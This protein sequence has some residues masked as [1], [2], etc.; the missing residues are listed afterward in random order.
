MNTRSSIL[1]RLTALR[2]SLPM[3]EPGARGLERVA[4]NP[5]CTRLRA[6]TIVGITPATAAT[7]VYGEPDREGISPFT[8]GLGIRF[9]RNLFEN[10]A[11]RLLQLYRDAGRL[12]TTECKVTI[13]PDL[14]P[15]LAT[16]NAAKLADTLARRQA[17]TDRLLRKK[18]AG[19]ADAPNIIIK[20]RMFVQ[21]LGIGHAVEPDALVA[22]DADRFYRPVEVKSY[23]DRDG[24]TEPSDIR[25][26]CRQAAVGIVALRSAASQFGLPISA[27]PAVGDLVLRVPG[28]MAAKLRPMT[29]SAEVASLDRAIGEAPRNLDELEAMLPQGG[30][31]DLPAILDQ[32]PTNYRTSCKE[33]CA[34]AGKCKQ[35]AVANGDPSLLGDA[36]RELL[37]AAGTLTRALDLMN[38]RGAPPRTAE[39]QVLAE[40][41]QEALA[42]YRRAI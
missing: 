40:Q 6:L 8:M 39:E 10:S 15:P 5:E 18:A 21:L 7:E 4:R 3:E 35:Q 36:T 22:A 20:P 33:H 38:L 42:L 9:E 34:L 12:S 41:L 29:L 2:G 37:A 26:A 27:V 24:K 17:E 23:L 31:M 30:T 1:D 16:R 13:V 32:I 25:G 11:S 19:S 14:A 28:S